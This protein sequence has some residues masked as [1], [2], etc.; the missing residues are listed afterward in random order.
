MNE[1]LVKTKVKKILFQFFKKKKT[2]YSMDTVITWDSLN[3]L[4]LMV[5]LQKEFTIELNSN[6]ISNSTDEKKIIKTIIRK[7]KKR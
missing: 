7:F 2:F 6:E 1:A 5:L 4:K 3:H